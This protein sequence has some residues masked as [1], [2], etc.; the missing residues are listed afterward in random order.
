MALNALAFGPLPPAQVEAATRLGGIE[1]APTS[2]GSGTATDFTS[3]AATTAG[4]TSAT[5]PAGATPS[6]TG[7]SPSDLDTALSALSTSLSAARL[8]GSVANVP[9]ASGA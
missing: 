8:A 6:L 9:E 1:S 5:A 7:S 4:S 3:P 2:T